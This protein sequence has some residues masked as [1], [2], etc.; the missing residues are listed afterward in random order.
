MSCLQ[1]RRLGFVPRLL[2]LLAIAYALSPLDLIPDF[3]PVLG[4][5]DDFFILGL[6]LYLA[7]RMVPADVMAAARERAKVRC[8]RQRQRCE[9]SLAGCQYGR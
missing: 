1:D 9:L 5:V 7:I 8:G 2:A 6:L 4:L 3:I